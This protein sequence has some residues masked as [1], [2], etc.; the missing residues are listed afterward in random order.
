M[1]AHLSAVLL[2]LS[3]LASCSQIQPE[4]PPDKAVDFVSQVKPLLESRCLECHHRRYVCA[5]LNLETKAL[6]MKG[7][8]S[9]PVIVPGAP[10]QSLLY[11]VLRLGHDN[12]VSM[13]PTP[14]SPE[15]EELQL[16]HDWI[17]QGAQWPA[18]VRLVPPQDWKHQRS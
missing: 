13:P 16:L 11:K 17:Q 9:G 2:F 4:L 18:D 10:H 7:G 3:G 5:G 6:A 15:P 8:R 1:K 12:P 14:E